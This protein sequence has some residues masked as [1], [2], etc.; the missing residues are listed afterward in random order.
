VLLP[1]GRAR[2]FPLLRRQTALHTEE[3]AVRDLATAFDTIHPIRPSLRHGYLFK[4]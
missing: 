2:T 3:F 4:L 1:G